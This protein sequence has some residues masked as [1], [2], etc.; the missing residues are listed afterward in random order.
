MHSDSRDRRWKSHQPKQAAGH[1]GGSGV[2]IGVVVAAAGGIG[3]LSCAPA[4]CQ[5]CTDWARPR[6]G[7]RA[8]PDPE[9]RSPRPCR[10]RVAQLVDGGGADGV[11]VVP[12]LAEVAQLKVAGGVQLAGDVDVVIDEAEEAR[13]QCERYVDRVRVGVR[14]KAVLGLGKE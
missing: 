2:S 10:P 13:L 4:R 8:A 14:L 5:M 1:G 3:R 9:H 7:A 11:G 6:V 12:A